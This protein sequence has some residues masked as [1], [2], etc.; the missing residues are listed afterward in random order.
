[1]KRPGPVSVAARLGIDGILD[2]ATTTCSG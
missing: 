1:V 2:R